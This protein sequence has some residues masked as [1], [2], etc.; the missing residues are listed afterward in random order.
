MRTCL[1]NE[2]AFGRSLLAPP[3]ANFRV[4]KDSLRSKKEGH[5]IMAA[6]SDREQGR[7]KLQSNYQ[8]SVFFLGPSQNKIFVL[9]ALVLPEKFRGEGSFPS[10]FV[11]ALFL[12][13]YVPLFWLWLIFVKGSFWQDSRSLNG[14]L[15]TNAGP[16]HVHKGRPS[17]RELAVELAAK[18]STA[19]SVGLL[20][21]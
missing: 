17:L 2:E 6:T 19:A 1:Q 8:V 20:L 16:V 10:A 5:R 11:S 18:I 21:L 9:I 13:L 14:P 12:V 3:A 4:S 15:L 7:E